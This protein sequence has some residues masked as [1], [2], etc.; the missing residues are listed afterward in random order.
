[1]YLN[2]GPTKKTSVNDGPLFMHTKC[3]NLKGFF[4]MVCV[5]NISNYHNCH[6]LQ[7]YHDLCYTVDWQPH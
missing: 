4:R 2:K 6:H 7:P 5:C 3:S 1:M